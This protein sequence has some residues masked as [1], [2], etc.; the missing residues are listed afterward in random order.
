LFR[1]FQIGSGAYLAVYILTH[2]NSAFI[3]A[4]AVHKIDTNWA[5]ASGAP[6]GLIHDAWDIR[7]LPH[8]ALGV[9][10]IAGHVSSGL[11][12]VML[13]HGVQSAVA[14]RVWAAGLT[15]GAATSIAIGCALCGVRL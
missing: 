13:A 9:F 12:V 4:R 1:V 6:V 14:N 7:L 3:S 15:A 2:M 11:R 8:Y 10:F 5:W